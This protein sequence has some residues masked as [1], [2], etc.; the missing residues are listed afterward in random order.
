MNKFKSIED[1]LGDPKGRY[2]GEGYKKVV[3]SQKSKD[4]TL[5]KI[6]SVFEIQYPS[7]W[8]TKKNIASI[9]PHL[10]TIDSIVIT[11]KLVTDFLREQLNFDE[12]TISNMVITEFTIKAGSVLVEDLKNIKA[13]LTLMAKNEF[14]F[15][16]KVASFSVE[17]QVT[18]GGK[19][20]KSN[21]DTGDDYY[22]SGFKLDNRSI[23]NIELG[24]DLK[25]V[26]AITKITHS[27]SFSGIESEYIFENRISSILNQIIVTAE[28]T[29]LL[30]SQLDDIPRELSKTLIMR[31]IKF[32][33]KIPNNKKTGIVNKVE[34][35]VSKSKIVQLK[36]KSVRTS[37]MVSKFNNSTLIYS[38]AQEL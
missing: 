36:G 38:V 30:H 24:T 31:K 28:L 14:H 9:K 8:S 10:S 1:I 26:C 29:E 19:L 7:S 6:T 17:L 5:E 2:F 22:F 32:I 25:S 15:K 12:D 23:T 16:G 34:I 11:I 3:Y 27:G 21:R 4:E 35:N 18:L 20:K 37:Q 13:E 33:R